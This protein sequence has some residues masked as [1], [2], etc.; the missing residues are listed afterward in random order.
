MSC[1]P[2]SQN[3]PAMGSS[4]ERCR[5]SGRL[6]TTPGSVGAWTW[7]GPP[8]PPGCMTAHLDSALVTTKLRATLR[9]MAGALAATLLVGCAAASSPGTMNLH[10]RGATTPRAAITAFL[11]AL[12]RRDTSGMREMMTPSTQDNEA[13]VDW[14]LLGN[15]PELT[16]FVIRDHAAES[17]SGNASPPGSIA[18][19][20]YT[21]ALTPAGG[22]DNSN[23]D[24]SAYNILVSESP[25]KRWLIAELGGCC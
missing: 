18:S 2:Q 9:A 11:E 7:P 4:A 17:T 15:P 14:G 3:R 12:E 23:T 5:R 25:Q 24:G 19:Q 21:V 20:R 1:H 13:N 8:E 16:S 22:F 10:P 6:R